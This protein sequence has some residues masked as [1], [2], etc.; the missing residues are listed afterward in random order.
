[1]WPESLLTLPSERPADA[2]AEEIASF[3]VPRLERG[4]E[5]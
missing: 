4:I 1:M 2:I 5:V 3:V